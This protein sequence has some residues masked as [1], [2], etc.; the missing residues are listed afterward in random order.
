MKIGDFLA[1][2]KVKNGP[3]AAGEYLCRCPAHD[4]RTA[5]LCV[6]EGD[7]GI[8]LKCQA[9][10][11]TQKVLDAMELQM[12]DLFNDDKK[13]QPKRSAAKP[14]AVKQYGSYEEAYGYLGKFVC[15]YQYQSADGVPLFEVARIDTSK[16]DAHDKTFRQH[17]LVGEGW[18]FPLET[19]VPDALKNALYR[20]PDVKAAIADGKPV[21]IVEGEKDADNMAKLGYAATTNA[22]GAEKWRDAHSEHLRGAD[23]RIIPDNDEPGQRHAEKVGGMLY[24]IAKSVKLL[25]I[26]SVC[27]KL[28]P[29]GDVT[30]MLKLLGKRKGMEALE[31]LGEQTEAMQPSDADTVRAEIAA[32]AE[33]YRNVSG[34]CVDNGRIC[35]QTQDGAKPLTNFVAMPRYVI[36]RDDGVNVTKEMIIDGWSMAGYRLPRVQIKANQYQGM[37]WITECW[38]F[39]ASLMPGNTVKE[40]VRYVIAEV[41]RMTVENKTVY[42]HTG[43]RKINGKW[44]YLHQGGAIGAEGVSVDLGASLMQYRLDGSDTPEWQELSYK[45]AGEYVLRLNEIMSPRISVPLLG[46]VYLAPMREFLAATGVGP[47]YALFLMGGTGTRKSTATALALSHYG[48]FTAK[49]LPAS[50][51]DTSNFIRKK[52]FLLKDMVIAVD[53]YHPVTSLQER[54]KME[55]T[56]Q[57]LARAF[58]DGAERGRLKADLSMSE[59]MPPRGVAIISGEDMPGIGESGMARFFVL[60]VDKED[61][62]VSDDM[63]Y[64]QER[65]R[66]GVLQKAM[67]GYIRWLAKQA[68]QLPDMLHEEFLKLRQQAKELS[69][70][71]HG[72]TAEAVAHVMLGYTSMLRYLRDVGTITTEQ[73]QAETLAA[74]TVITESSKRQNEEARENRPSKIFLQSIGELL[75]SKVAGVRDLNENATQGSGARDMIGY[76]DNDYYY[77]LPEMAYRVVAKLYND[78]GVAFPLQRLMLYKQ[79]REDGLLTPDNAGNPTRGKCVDGQTQRVLWVPRV[80]I[81]GKPKQEDKQLRIDDIPTDCTVVDGSDMP[82]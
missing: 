12:K 46:T 40:K 39:S 68:D 20:L 31:Q 2:L 13:P 28:P 38:D 41:G 6:R 56:A 55:A 42:N 77:L 74:W 65:A 47:A 62:P 30:D 76:K 82:F 51:N 44:A 64:M 71:Q 58:G 78:Q 75:T 15:A 3:S 18:T 63:T 29:K 53:D 8:V 48:N 59:A 60:S 36:S 10:C 37:A 22:M 70:D 23:V 19:G 69:A 72:R 34:Y 25:N 14:A 9:G 33:K 27:P 49:S 80:N 24:G 17:R 52:A 32:A 16:G 26:A 67:N 81:D 66:A 4:D 7:K 45:A 54:K 43:W 73:A 5:S 21:Y 1:R 61:I 50:F 11:S 57:S 79:M 35:M